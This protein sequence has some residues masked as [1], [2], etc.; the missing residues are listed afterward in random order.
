MTD[1]LLISIFVA[2][3]GAHA[4]S[5]FM[6]SAF[7]IRSFARDRADFDN[8][9]SGYIPAVLFI[10]ALAFTVAA[11]KKSALPILIAGATTVGMIALYEFSI[12]ARARE[13]EKV[14]MV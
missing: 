12:T 7:T 13:L 3:E 1:T 8:L 11:I 14:N 6:P 2:V 9:R 5:A 10:M 4:F